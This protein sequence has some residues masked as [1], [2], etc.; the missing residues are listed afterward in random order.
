MKADE[1]RIWR[2]QADAL[3]W[4]HCSVLK[5]VQYEAL[6]DEQ[7]FDRAYRFAAARLAEEFQ[8]AA[9]IDHDKLGMFAACG[10]IRVGIS[11]GPRDIRRGVELLEE[12]GI[13]MK[14]EHVALIVGM[15]DSKVRVTNTGQVRIE[16]KLADLAR[17]SVRDKSAALSTKAIK[18]AIARSGYTF[19]HEQRAAIHAL[20]EGGA[21]T[22]LTGVAGAGKTTLLEPL[23]DAWKADK[24][25]MPGP[26]ASLRR[27]AADT[28]E[29]EA[30]VASARVWLFEH[31]YVIPPSR[32]LRQ[33][34]VAARRRHDERLFAKVDAAV[35]ADVR[36]DRVAQL[37]QPTD[38]E[39]GASRLDWLRAGPVSKKPQGLADHVAKVSFLKTL[40][41]DRLALDISLAG[42]RH[43]ARS[44]LYRK[45]AAL[46]LMR[47]PRRTCPAP[48]TCPTCIDECRAGSAGHRATGPSCTMRRIPNSTTSIMR[49]SSSARV[50]NWS[51]VGCLP[52]V[53][54]LSIQ[55]L[56]RRA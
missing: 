14:G 2:E 13:Q 42:L 3:G 1:K 49:S 46:P 47:A 4:R 10:L 32:R 30:L 53:L 35:P 26:I 19:T 8:T 38:Q 37:L 33:L 24:R 21:L 44:M 50:I 52:N 25:V 48:V 41:A 7:R 6:P 56:R 23:V 12:R 28:F 27:A 29:V 54:A 20:A 16:E 5:D 31:R 55:S 34:A 17:G 40:G 18:A 9:V 51:G 15:T 22:M 45:P 39:T 43:Y 36:A 11:G